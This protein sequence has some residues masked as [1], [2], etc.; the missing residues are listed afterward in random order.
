[1]TPEYRDLT[2]RI[3]NYDQSFGNWKRLLMSKEFD[4][5]SSSLNSVVKL[6]ILLKKM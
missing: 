6:K 1:M 4:F 5:K 2:E 3:C